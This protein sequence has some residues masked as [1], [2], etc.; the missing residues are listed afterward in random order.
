MENGGGSAS[1]SLAHL[2]AP[3]Y[4]PN[5]DSTINKPYNRVHKTQPQPSSL[6]YSLYRS[7]ASQAEVLA[8]FTPSRYFQGKL[9]NPA[10]SLRL[11]SSPC[12]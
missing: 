3:G 2:Q 4:Y 1:F 7:Q 5:S 6:Q 9:P 12:P 11:R 10:C 8:I